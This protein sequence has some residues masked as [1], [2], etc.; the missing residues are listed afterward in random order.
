[1]QCFCLA[2]K[3][4]PFSWPV[5]GRSRD[6]DV[7]VQFTHSQLPFTT[8]GMNVHVQ[9]THLQSLIV[10]VR[11]QCPFH[12]TAHCYQL[13]CDTMCIL[14]KDI[15]CNSWTLNVHVQLTHCRSHQ[16]LKN[17]CSFFAI[18][19]FNARSRHIC[20]RFPFMT[21]RYLKI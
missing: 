14:E 4:T 1:M 16:C 11:L 10:T 18:G 3:W 7:H 8:S 17:F 9:L 21:A 2:L 15:C 19:G 5:I 13:L 12:E 20:A 6:Y